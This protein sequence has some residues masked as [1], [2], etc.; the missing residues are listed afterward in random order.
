M[1]E[2]RLLGS[3]LGQGYFFGRPLSNHITTGMPS[4]LDAHRR[5]TADRAAP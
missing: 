5:W 2:L 3:E 4:L 1:A